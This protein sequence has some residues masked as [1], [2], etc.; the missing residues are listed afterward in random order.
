MAL[1]RARALGA[2]AFG[3]VAGAEGRVPGPGLAGGGGAGRAAADGLPAAAAGLA[4]GFATGHPATLGGGAAALA[5][6]GVPHRAKNLKLAALSVM[7]FGHCFGG[8]PACCSLPAGARAADGF[9]MV[10]APA[11]SAGNAAPHERHEPTSVSLWA[12]HFG[13][14]MWPFVVRAPKEGQGSGVARGATFLHW[15]KRCTCANLRRYPGVLKSGPGKGAVPKSCPRCQR[16]LPPAAKRLCVYC[17]APL[18]RGATDPGFRPSQAA[19]GDALVGTV[20]SGRFRV[21]DLI[22]QGGMGKGYRA[23]HLA[24]ERAVALN[25]LKPPLLQGP[26]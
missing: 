3:G 23:R 21:D 11:S 8:P 18:V 16:S 12:P 7:Q 22:G 9:I 4:S 14:S 10:G 6:S 20:I 24:L 17:G 26:T 2:L 15:K 1:I 25:G 5:V 19:T 13:H